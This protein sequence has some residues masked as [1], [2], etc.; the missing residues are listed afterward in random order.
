MELFSEIEPDPYVQDMNERGIP[1]LL[2]WAEG[3]A[4]E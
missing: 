2:K 3:E 1:V 4:A